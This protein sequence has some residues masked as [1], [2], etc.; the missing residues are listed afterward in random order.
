MLCVE[1]PCFQLYFTC[2]W[3]TF[4]VGGSFVLVRVE[5]KQKVQ[6][7]FKGYFKVN[8]RVLGAFQIVF[9]M[10]QWINNKHMLRNGILFC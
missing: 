6:V 8:G 2:A 1:V 3:Y 10:F 4:R 5:G 9:K 7:S